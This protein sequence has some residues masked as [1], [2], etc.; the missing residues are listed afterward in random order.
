MVAGSPCTGKSPPKVMNPSPCEKPVIFMLLEVMAKVGQRI[1]TL[2]DLASN[3][4]YITH[5]AARRLGLQG[6]KVLIAIQGRGGMANNVTTKRY[7]LAVKI[8]TPKCTEGLNEIAKMDKAVKAEQLKKFFPNPDLED[9]RRPSNIE[10]LISH[11]EGRL[12]KKT[13]Y[14]TGDQQLKP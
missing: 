7:L 11:H 6:E 13:R 2:I 3:V 10:L 12:I 8:K 9:L 5:R 4:N 1:G 14:S